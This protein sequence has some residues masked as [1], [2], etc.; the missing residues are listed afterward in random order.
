MRLR[1][2]EWEAVM[3]ETPWSSDDNVQENSS[4]PAVYISWND[5]QRFIDKLND[6]LGD[7]LYRL[8]SEAEWEVCVSSGDFDSLVFWG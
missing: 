6:A 5:V 2:G 4:H 8:P 7:S 1:R 3:G